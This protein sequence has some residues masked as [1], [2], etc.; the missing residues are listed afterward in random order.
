MVNAGNVFYVLDNEPVT[1][2]ANGSF[3]T[4]SLPSQ[5]LPFSAGTNGALSA[6]TGGIIPD[7]LLAGQ[8]DL[9]HG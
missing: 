8:P 3:P 5:I 1:I 6:E 4:G 9:P 2:P 7:R